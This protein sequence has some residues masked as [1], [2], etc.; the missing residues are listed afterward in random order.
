MTQPLSL[1]NSP[2]FQ[3]YFF[4]VFVVL[5]QKKIATVLNKSLGFKG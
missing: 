5:V 1:L 2:A 3:F 4:V